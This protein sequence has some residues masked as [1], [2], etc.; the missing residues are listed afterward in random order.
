[1]QDSS[2]YAAATVLAFYGVILNVFRAKRALPHI[3]V[4]NQKLDLRS[5]HLTN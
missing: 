1:V 4:S 2:L 5:R 3:N